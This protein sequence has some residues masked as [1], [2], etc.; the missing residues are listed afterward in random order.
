MPI[1]SS[2]KLAGSGVQVAETPETSI[3]ASL[4]SRSLRGGP[5]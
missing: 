5:P 1:P 3:W 4:K 2:Q